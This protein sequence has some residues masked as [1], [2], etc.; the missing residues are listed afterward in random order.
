MQ[1]FDSGRSRRWPVSLWLI[2]AILGSACG[3]GSDDPGSQGTPTDTDDNASTTPDNLPNLS[4]HSSDV[5]DPNLPAEPADCDVI[6][7]T[8]CVASALDELSN[9]L[10]AGHGGTFSTDLSR[11]ELTEANAD[12]TFDQP[13][14]RWSNALELHFAIHTG[15]E[16]CALYAEHPQQGFASAIDLA[17]KHHRVTVQTAEDLQRTLTC[18]D[19]SVTFRQSNLSQCHE[20]KVAPTPELVDQTLDGVYQVSPMQQSN[21]RIFNCVFPAASR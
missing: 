19:V 3:S 17:T 5:P 13:V 2:G 14:P 18:D 20:S 6:E 9:C 8:S 10:S 11:C 4:T 21:R 12:V 15:G 7:L 16:V 1:S